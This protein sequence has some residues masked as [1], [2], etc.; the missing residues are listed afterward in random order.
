LDG[1]PPWLLSKNGAELVKSDIHYLGWLYL[2]TGRSKRITRS[3]THRGEASK[4]IKKQI[5]EPKAQIS[6]VVVVEQVEV[7]DVGRITRKERGE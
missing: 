6:R 2:N 4:G 3:K 1:P 7:S 5:S